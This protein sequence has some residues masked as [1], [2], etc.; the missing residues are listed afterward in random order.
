MILIC[1]VLEKLPDD[2]KQNIF[3]I[4]IGKILKEEDNSL[5][6]VHRFRNIQLVQ[7]TASDAEVDSD[8]E[9]ESE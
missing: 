3:N 6:Y 5:F 9:Y 4:Y 8:F 2:I 1:K 7:Y